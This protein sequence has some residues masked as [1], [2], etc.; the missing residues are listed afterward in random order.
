M[1]IYKYFKYLLENRTRDLNHK[2][3]QNSFPYNVAQNTTGK[4]CINGFY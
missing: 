4:M 1:G 2:K 3:T